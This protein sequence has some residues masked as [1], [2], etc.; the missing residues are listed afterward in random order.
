MVGMSELAKQRQEIEM[1][2]LH[3]H[4]LVA[5]RQGNFTHSEVMHLSAQ[6]DHLIVEYQ[7]LERKQ[8]NC[9]KT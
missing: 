1:M 3:L 8:G 6:M 2:R 7:L 4:D 9:P 5:S